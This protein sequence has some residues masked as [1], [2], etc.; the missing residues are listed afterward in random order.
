MKW[1][2]FAV[3]IAGCGIDQSEPTQTL[4]TD[5]HYSVLFDPWPTMGECLENLP[6]EACAVPMALSLCKNGRAVFYKNDVAEIGTY[7]MDEADTGETWV[8]TIATQR[9]LLFFDVEIQ[10]LAGTSKLE[11]LDVGSRRQDVEL[12]PRDV[13]SQHHQ[14]RLRA[15]NLAEHDRIRFDG[16]RSLGVRVAHAVRH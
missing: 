3:A 4:P 10:E 15:G 1:L 8:A 13:G 16:R 2:V 6:P 14:P 11:P 12:E 7:A 5:A 9:S